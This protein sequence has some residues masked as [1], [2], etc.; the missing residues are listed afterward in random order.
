[1]RRWTMVAMAL[2]VGC[3]DAMDS[4]GASGGPITVELRPGGAETDIPQGSPYQVLYC[5]VS[6]GLRWCS[7]VTRD[8]MVANGRVCDGNMTC[9]EDLAF[10]PS[11]EGD[12]WLQ[13][14][15]WPGL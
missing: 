2:V 1:M 9:G 10:T 4:A 13:V 3:G 14:S 5:E 6:S 15:Y 7:D 11:G 12:A 8:Y